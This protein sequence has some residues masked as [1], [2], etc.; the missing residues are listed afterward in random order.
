MGNTR[1]V[2]VGMK[3]PVGLGVGEITTVGVQV[4]GKTTGVAVA[5]GISI[6]GGKV[7]GGKGL[8]EEFGLPKITNT[9][10]IMIKEATKTTMERISQT[11]SFIR[12][13]PPTKI[14]TICSFVSI[15]DFV[16]L[17][18]RRS[19][20]SFSHAGAWSPKRTGP[21]RGE[22]GENPIYKILKET[23]CIVLII[24]E[25]CVIRKYAFH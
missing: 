22:H 25:I 21:G 8:R 20:A 9:T 2:S 4:A 12:S 6:I 5:V 3:V 18:S 17:S 11:L 7:A 14:N 15:S 1:G 24:S 23:A 16:P 10:P 13:L 19:I